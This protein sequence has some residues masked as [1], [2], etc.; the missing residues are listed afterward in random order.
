MIGFYKANLL[1]KT[2]LRE[3]D[4]NL[5]IFLIEFYNYSHKYNFCCLS[6]NEK[7]THVNNTCFTVCVSVRE[8][9]KERM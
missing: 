7:T 1:K 2:V 5:I 9:T 3:I 4:Y 8:E 6:K